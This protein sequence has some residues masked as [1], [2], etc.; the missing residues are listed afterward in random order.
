MINSWVGMGR[1]TKDVELKQ[2][3]SGKTY[4]RFTVAIDSLWQKDKSNFIACIAWGKTAEFIGKYFRK[5]SMIALEGEVTTDKYEKDGRTVYTTDINVSRVSFTGEKA[6]S[7]QPEP[8][9][10]DGFEETDWDIPF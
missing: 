8:E 6:T 2:T 9:A 5:G 7:G 10:P 1:L 3:Q 4:T